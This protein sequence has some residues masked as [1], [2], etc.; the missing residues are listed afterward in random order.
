MSKQ[1]VCVWCGELLDGEYE[2]MDGTSALHE[3]CAKTVA[4]FAGKVAEDYVELAHDER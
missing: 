4:F 3:D 2:T 1:V